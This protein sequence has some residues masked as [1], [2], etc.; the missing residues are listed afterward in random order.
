MSKRRTRIHKPQLAADM[1]GDEVARAVKVLNRSRYI[2]GLYKTYGQD[3]VTILNEQRAL[4]DDLT[5]RGIWCMFDDVEAELLYLFIREMGP[6]MALEI[7]SGS[8]WSTT[9]MLH[10]LKSTGGRLLSLDRDNNTPSFVPSGLAGDR[11]S[12]FRMDIRDAA[13]ESLAQ[14][15]FLLV[16][17]DHQ[18]HVIDWIIEHI[19]PLVRPGGRIAVHD[20]FALATP[21]HG[22][23]VRIFRYLD[24]IGVR[25]YTPSR[26]FPASHRKINGAR[27]EAGIDPDN[28][29]CPNKVNPLLVFDVP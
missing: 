22:E 27:R 21:A 13:R 12:F 4:H 3:L 11:W 25:P 9:W 15:D 26:C 24:R 20:V 10:A 6:S 17:T 2:A 23:A 14:L 29:I 28:L 16:D 18:P 19:F 5:R 7:G 1:T 8:G